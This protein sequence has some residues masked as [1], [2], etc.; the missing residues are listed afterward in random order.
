M[1][2][3][4]NESFQVEYSAMELLSASSELPALLTTPTH[5]MMSH[6]FQSPVTPTFPLISSSP[7]HAP[8]SSYQAFAV[9]PKSLSSPGPSHAATSAFNVLPKAVVSSPSPS[10][11][12]KAANPTPT[13]T[14][15]THVVKPP[16]FESKVSPLP[17]PAPPIPSRPKKK[18]VPKEKRRRTG[19][20]LK[21]V[22]RFVTILSG[23]Y[24]G[25]DGFVTRG[26]NG[27]YSVAFSADANLDNK[28]VMKRAGDLKEIQRPAGF[29]DGPHNQLAQDAN[30]EE[31]SSKR[32]KRNRP[33]S[34]KESWIE[35]NVIVKEGKYRGEIGLVKRSGHGFY[36]IHFPAYGEVMKR[37]IDLELYDEENPQHIALVKRRQSGSLDVD[38]TNLSP[39]TKKTYRKLKASQASHKMSK[40]Q[41]LQP[42]YYEDDR[43]SDSGSDFGRQE[44]S[45]EHAAMILIQMQRDDSSTDVSSGLDDSGS[46]DEYLRPYNASYHTP[47]YSS[48]GGRAVI[49]A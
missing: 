7:T 34:G 20:K 39:A 17:P 43:A 28:V 2:R 22:G 26:A 1:V 33:V 44:L 48:T 3:V 13:P 40:S 10:P 18:A 38:R 4:K 31:G 45:F 23:R 19:T 5:Q 12:T 30:T 32:R 24:A 36:C 8:A 27:Y 29:V 16:V 21:L 46:E 35:Q 47:F 15:T 25:N 9:S 14:P 41:D 42:Y 37:G 11:I 49:R 6:R